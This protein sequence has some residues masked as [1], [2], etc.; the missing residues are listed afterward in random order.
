MARMKEMQGLKREKRTIV[1]FFEIM[2]KQPD[3]WCRFLRI[4]TIVAVLVSA[5]FLLYA[6]PAEGQQDYIF[7]I[8]ATG[9]MV[10]LPPGSGNLNIMP[11]VQVALVELA[12]SIPIG[13]HVVVM[14]FSDVIIERFEIMIKNDHDVERLQEYFMR[15]EPNGKRTYIYRALLEAEKV[16]KKMRGDSGAKHQQLLLYTDGKDN[17]PE[18][19]TM[20]DQMD[21]FSRMRRDNKRLFLFY[22][23]LGVD[24]PEKEVRLLKKTEGVIHNPA[25]K[26]ESP[27]MPKTVADFSASATTGEE[28]LV[29][30][31]TDKSTGPVLGWNWQFGDGTTS[32]EQHPKHEYLHVREYT[33]TLVVTGSTGTFTA[34]KENYIKVNRKPIPPPLWKKLLWGFFALVIILLLAY[35]VYCMKQGVGLL[36]GVSTLAETYFPKLDGELE[37]IEPENMKQ[38]FSLK[39]KKSVR[40]GKGG[41]ILSEVDANFRIEPRTYRGKRA[42]KIIV[43]DQNSI[44]KLNGLP[45][46]AEPIY[47]NYVIEVDQEV[48][49]KIRYNNHELQEP[50]VS[51]TNLSSN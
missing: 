20:Q 9:S 10:G 34:K 32:S 16:A 45:L 26:G 18:K 40:V 4:I 27:I 51:E 8:D 37:V 24:L 28:R 1:S 50:L 11:K 19:R 23:T 2:K 43:D 41:D 49:V 29:V 25:P 33:V 17:D 44:V 12:K 47:D 15:I 30:E 35:V 36:E 21:L 7:L 14:P 6:Q 46:Y 39:G 13:S 22:Y 38:I 42:I 48:P 5:S 3:L 31:F